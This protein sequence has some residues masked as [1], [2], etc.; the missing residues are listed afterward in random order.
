M[1]KGRE[2]EAELIK[3]YGLKNAREVWK[4]KS[5]ARRVKKLAR[6]LLAR[7][8]RRVEED[9]MGRLVGMGLVNSK[10][11]LDDILNITVEDILDRRLQTVVYKKGLATS[12]KQARQ[13]IVHGHI[14]VRGRRITAPGHLV[15]IAEGLDIQFYPRSP[16]NNPE[17]PARNPEK[18]KQPEKKESGEETT[19]DKEAKGDK[20][21]SETEEEKALGTKNQDGGREAKDQ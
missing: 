1:F 19:E 4:A 15:T 3:R 13:E 2:D 12:I 6:S 16:L 10:G 14:M 8:N 11:Q 7:P 5:E 20:T 18:K 17:H 21:G 9:L